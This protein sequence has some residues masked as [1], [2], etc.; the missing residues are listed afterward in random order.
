MCSVNGPHKFQAFW[1]YV[2]LMLWAW[3]LSLI[4]CRGR[5]A[6]FILNYLFVCV[7]VPIWSDHAFR[8]QCPISKKLFI[9]CSSNKTVSGNVEVEEMLRFVSGFNLMYGIIQWIVVCYFCV[10]L[11][12]RI[13]LIGH[14]CRQPRKKDLKGKKKRLN[15]DFNLFTRAGYLAIWMLS[16]LHFLPTSFALL[17]ALCTHVDVYTV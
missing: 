11:I 12:Q 16:L 4:S 17:L 10:F 2:M 7:L 15:G 14:F 3:D 9:S 6:S 13:S 5:E 1:I 8:V